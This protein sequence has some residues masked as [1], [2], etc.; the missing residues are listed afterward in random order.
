MAAYV[1][2]S[3]TVLAGVGSTCLRDTLELTGFL[4]SEPLV[5]RLSEKCPN[6]VGIKDTTEDVAHLYGMVNL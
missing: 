4:F 3:V 6:I 5:R 1:D 2:G